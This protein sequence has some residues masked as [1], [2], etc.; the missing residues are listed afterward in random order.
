MVTTPGVTTVSND[1]V[2]TFMLI[3]VILHVLNLFWFSLIVRSVS[4]KAKKQ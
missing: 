1:I 2:Y 4:R 3:N